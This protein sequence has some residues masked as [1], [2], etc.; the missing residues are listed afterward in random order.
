MWSLDQA[1][2]MQA[3]ARWPKSWLLQNQAAPF[4]WYSADEAVSV[5]TVT[6]GAVN[7]W[8]DAGPG[9]RTFTQGTGGNQPAHNAA[10]DQ[11]DF[12]GGD[13]LNG[14]AA[15]IDSGNSPFTVVGIGKLDALGT[16]RTV[17]SQGASGV[18]HQ[19]PHMGFRTAGG[20]FLDGWNAQVVTADGVVGTTNP[21]LVTWRYTSGDRKVHCF[22]AQMA[23]DAYS[24]ANWQTGSPMIGRDSFAVGDY[25]DGKLNLLL[26]YKS[27]LAIPVRHRVEG[28]AA[29]YGQDTYTPGQLLSTFHPY[30]ARPPQD[31]LQWSP[32][33][34]GNRLRAWYDVNDAA[35]V[36]NVSG[37]CSNLADKSGWGNHL[38]QGTSGNRPA[39]SATG[40]Q[41]K[42][43][44]TFTGSSDHYL[45]NAAFY[46]GASP[47]VYCF[48]AC[49][50]DSSGFDNYGR[51]VAF[52]SAGSANDHD[53]TASWI[54][55]RDATNANIR[56]HANALATN[57][58]IPGYATPMIVG[59]YWDGVNRVIR[60]GL[61]SASAAQVI[62]TAETGGFW[63]GTGST[64]ESMSGKV[65][66]MLIVVGQ[67][68]QEEINLVMLYLSEKW[69]IDLR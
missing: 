48:A 39:Y 56:V 55:C 25:Y 35:T 50:W 64:I 15:M 58:A 2:Q 8:G 57:L 32:I 21:W 16:S 44:L 23:G 66:E 59:G 45:S 6:G 60:H 11:I 41:G 14:A 36:T 27:A 43:G 38:S 31:H 63:L 47:Y 54:I 37:A 42:G 49:Q 18:Q 34:L 20:V 51:L 22:G 65:G 10:N 7:S 17:Y 67:M 9:G 19:A 29:W 53:N 5:V 33:L 13:N 1:M 40:F 68:S 52:R 61:F 12:D 62:G 46:H 30:W 4:S 28:W 26:F 69:G 24:S 3:E